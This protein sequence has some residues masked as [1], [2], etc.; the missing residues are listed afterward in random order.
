M[1]IAINGSGTLTGI[2]TGGISDTKAIADAAMPAGSVIQIVEG[3]HSTQVINS[4]TTL[5]DTNLSASITPSSSS[6]KILVLVNQAYMTDRDTG[7]GVN[8]RL[9]LLRDSTTIIEHT[10][11]MNNTLGFSV[12]N[13]NDDLTIG[14]RVPLSKLDSPNTTSSVTYKTQI[15]PIATS[16]NGICIGQPSDMHSFIQLLEIAA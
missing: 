6:N 5:T 11:G 2:S 3:T 12:Q 14:M 10:T 13:F 15:A 16:N 4:S 8:G 1:P 7:S 9:V